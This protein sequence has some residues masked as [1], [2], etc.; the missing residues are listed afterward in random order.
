MQHE[1]CSCSNVSLTRASSISFDHGHGGLE[2]WSA[3]HVLHC[4]GPD[5]LASIRR[6]PGAAAV[7]ACGEHGRRITRQLAVSSL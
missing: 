2:F 1:R 7:Q 4:G 6:R 3:A 5:Q